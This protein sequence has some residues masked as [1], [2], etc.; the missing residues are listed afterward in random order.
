MDLKFR[1][2]YDEM[3]MVIKNINAYF[4]NMYGKYND[5]R[6]WLKRRNKKET[7]RRIF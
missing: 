6:K 5:N 1:E 7:E 3:N 4:I 2:G